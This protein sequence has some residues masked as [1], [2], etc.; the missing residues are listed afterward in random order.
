MDLTMIY[1]LLHTWFYAWVI[2]QT[3]K[4]LGVI[5]SATRKSFS[6]KK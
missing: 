2:F 1:E 3:L 5:F 6:V 4:Q